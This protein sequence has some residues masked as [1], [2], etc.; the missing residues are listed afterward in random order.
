MNKLY[1]HLLALRKSKLLI[2]ALMFVLLFGVNTPLS[3]QSTIKIS[4][5]VTNE[6]GPQ[7][8]AS[9]LI[10]EHPLIAVVTDIEGHFEINAPA[11]S[12]TLVISYIGYKTEQVAIGKRTLINVE[13]TPD[14]AA[15]DEVVVVGYGEQR[16]QFIVGSI[17]NVTSDELLKAPS[18]NLSSMLSGR[19]AGMTAIQSTGTPGGDNL[20]MLIRGASTF[21]DA[22]PLIIV[23]G[24]ER[25]ITYLNP[26]DVKSVTILKDAATAAI[27]GVRG[28]NGVIMVTTKSGERGAASINYEG[29]YT[30][31]TNTAMPEMLDADEYIYWHNYARELDGQLPYWT[32]ANLSKMQ[33]MGILGDTDWL[34]EIYNDFGVTN[35]HNVSASG[36]SEKINYFASIGM[37]DQEGILKNTDFKR[38]NIRGNFDA[39][40]SDNL[41]FS[42]NIGGATTE[43]NWPGLNITQ[44]SEFS[45]ITQAFYALPLLATEYDGLPLG[46][47]NGTYTF[48]PTAALEDSGYQNQRRYMVDATSKL[49]YSFSEASPLKGLKASMF[50]AYNFNS[51]LDHVYSSKFDLYQFDINGINSSTGGLTESYSQG[52]PTNNFNKSNSLGWQLTLRPQINY[53][54]DFGRHSIAALL[55]YE[56]YKSYSDTMTGYKTG[57][58]VDNPI[59]ISLGLENLS[60]YVTGS[61]YSTGMA[62]YAGRFNYAFDKRYLLEFTFRADGSYKFAPENRWGYFPS[63]AA[64]WIISEESFFSRIKEKV[65]FLKLRASFGILGSDDV[66]PFL[67][68]QSF[69]STAP[70]Y[71]Y[72]IEGQPMAVYY[73]S[74]Y[75]YEDLTWSKTRTYNVG[76]DLKAFDGLLEMEADLFYKHTV[77]IL[78][79]ISSGASYPPSLGG[80]NP[81]I[82]NSGSVDNRG[83]EVTLT[84]RNKIGSEFTYG[85]TGNLAWSRN[86]VLAREISDSYPTY[87]SV[88]GQPMGLIYGFESNG[89]FQTQE[90]VNDYPT[91]P[92]GY[93]AIGEIM[94]VDQNGD[95]KIDQTHD[96]VQIGRSRTPEMNFSLNI[97]L[98]WR[99]FSLSTL[100]QGVAMANYQLNGVYANGNTD[101][102]MYTR[103]FYGGGNTAL[104]LVENSW[105][106]DNTDAEY[107]RLRATTNANNAWSSDYWIV[108]GSYLRVKN[109]QL[110]YA[111]PSDLLSRIKIKAASVYIA[112]TNLLTLSHFKYV[113]PENP[114]INNGYYPQQR[115]FSIGLKLTL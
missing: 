40:I 102:S 35:Q 98:A 12:K 71:A 90:Q 34:S 39:K 37:M 78:E 95:G 49:E 47:T 1:T 79:S 58:Y 83:F 26:S 69:N 19:L 114:G 101:S 74:G 18:T 94:Y 38:Y 54:R 113:D 80:N 27:Y 10:E 16:K 31:T 32:E 112:G 2:F 7:V 87:R 76:V 73:T 45:P 97:D 115:T 25:P 20:N 99:N 53:E 9:V 42:M 63:V 68:L 5:T 100:L 66:S 81:S 59:D 88:I 84:H 48:T 24:V 8:G 67:H 86:K 92:S 109:V 41:R 77:D 106:P 17:S 28:A 62:S 82:H 23:D 110:S 57:Y 64:G 91:A 46:Y 85:L 105:T 65:D 111:L 43:R 11:G 4:G 89:L 96:Y 93:T 33:S 3:A 29:S 60:P 107:P 36:G 6:A 55:L 14:V 30:L 103:P 51:T 44:Q 50:M 108:D 15:L 61:H 22:S 72:V 52:I 13:M 70:G 75:V 56:S 21:N 104:Y